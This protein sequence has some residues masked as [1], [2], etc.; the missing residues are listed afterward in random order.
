M[1]LFFEGW[2]DVA[3]VVVVSIV[4]VVVGLFIVGMFEIMVYGGGVS[5]CGE[6]VEWLVKLVK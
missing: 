4:L 2:K 5:T 6:M 3:L 1:K